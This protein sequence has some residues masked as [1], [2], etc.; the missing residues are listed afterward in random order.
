MYKK[1][2]FI[3]F[4]V[5]VC[6]YQSSAQTHIEGITKNN[7]DVAVPFVTLTV[8]YSDTAKISAFGFSDAT[9]KFSIIIKDSI[10]HC[11]VNAT[12][13]GFA[14]VR[15]NLSV[16][17]NK[18]NTVDFVLTEETIDIKSLTIKASRPPVKTRPDTTT[19]RVKSFIDSSEHVVEDV[20]RKLP[21]IQ[22]DDNGGIKY[23]G[24]AIERILIE[25]DDLFNR[26]YKIPSKNLSAG[27]LEEV[28]VID[29]YSSN[30]LLKKLENSDRLVLNLNFKKDRIK[31]WFGNVN[32]GGGVESKYDAAYNLITF[33]KKLKLFNLGNFN[34]AGNDASP[35]LS[36]DR[37][38][39][40]RQNSDFYDPEI[41]AAGIINSPLLGGLILK[42]ERYNFNQAAFSS[43]NFID[44]PNDKLQI[45]GIG[46]FYSDNFTQN[47]NSETQY[48]L[49]KQSFS[50]TDS[51]NVVSKPLYGKGSLEATYR[52][53]EES[54]IMFSSELSAKK[55]ETTGATILNS[56]GFVQ[57][58]KDKFQYWKNLLNYTQK[59]SDSLAV[60]F[61]ATFSNDAR[62][63]SFVI[64]PSQNFNSLFPSDSNR[65]A[66]TLQNSEVH[67]QFLGFEAQLL[68]ALKNDKKLSLKIG[69]SRQIDD[70]FS[71]IDLF[72]LNN[73][74]QNANGAF[75]N[76]LTYKE[77][78]FFARTDFTKEFGN[79]SVTGLVGLNS[80]NGNLN[81]Y[82]NDSNNYNKNWI[83]PD[84]SLRTKWNVNYA[85]KI[86]V[87]YKFNSKSADV[88]NL[89]EGYVLNNYNNFTRN[90]I[91]QTQ[92]ASHS[93]S[94][95]YNYNDDF[96]NIWGFLNASYSRTENGWSSR[97]IFSP[98]Y[99]LTTRVS[100]TLPNENIIILGEV[101]KLVSKINLSFKLSTNQFWFINYNSVGNENFSKSINWSS[102]YGGSLV[103]TYS[104]FFNFSMGG[105]WNRNI[106]YSVLDSQ[107][108]A[109]SSKL[110][111]AYLK[112]KFNFSAKTFFFIT[113]DFY[114]SQSDFS[115]SPNHIFTDFELYHTIIPQKL[116][117][118]IN[119]KNIF[120][121]ANFVTSS[122]SINQS[123]FSSYRLVPRFFIV[124]VDC[125]F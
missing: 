29:R 44:K 123:S 6:I 41:R 26:D 84:F 19:F 1:L 22:I 92:I 63:Q 109:P 65:L 9:G 119:F 33:S 42:R 30:P 25:G 85:N 17:K 88:N 112:L 4:V 18:S 91:S 34:N 5:R 45:K 58:L 97:Q 27:I 118:S 64:N 103:S 104:G 36:L 90:T 47:Q 15:K 69:G 72:Y 94:L 32:A 124:K 59:L 98:F 73:E 11:T 12:L 70:L 79:V 43:L 99:N 75:T 46:A 49:G 16:E 122:V 20:L 114:A 21:G 101:S 95:L 125:R 113:N 61:H 28:Q 93:V 23:Q 83:Y 39:N 68:G 50:T 82:L 67:T 102:K 80:L 7:A 96:K 2:I 105:N 62:T 51:Q 116:N 100:S 14:K 121:I 37:L 76:N 74:R 48:L 110:I 71:N 115:K 13:L 87:S 107:Q 81:N 54:L 111:D 117:L 52:L 53:S 40:Q 66:L 38:M 10:T 77:T 106:N 78:H 35:E 8:N 57:N 108:N 31:R 3:F 120:N 60:V 86:S 56:N 89:F 55:T 24:R